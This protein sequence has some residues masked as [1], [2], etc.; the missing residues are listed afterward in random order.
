MKLKAE[1]YPLIADPGSVIF[2][3]EVKA[4]LDTSQF[5]GEYWE[6]WDRLVKCRHVR[7]VRN[8][9]VS[10]IQKHSRLVRQVAEL[11]VEAKI[12]PCW[13]IYGGFMIGVAR[14]A[15]DLVLTAICLRNMVISAGGVFTDELGDKTTIPYDVSVSSII[16]GGDEAAP[17]S[18]KSLAVFFGLAVPTFLEFAEVETVTIGQKSAIGKRYKFDDEKYINYLDAEVEIID[19]RWFRSIVRDQE[20]G[21]SGHF[22]LQPYGPGRAKRKLVYIKDFIKHGY[23]RRAGASDAE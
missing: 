12:E 2:D 14:C 21:V 6:A 9:I 19:S 18:M 10:H 3:P 1:D 5:A 16:A 7:L 17:V 20:F 11:A 8:T 4:F 23:H 13:Y 22:R 15:P